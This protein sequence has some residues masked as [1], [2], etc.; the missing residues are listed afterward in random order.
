MK[1]NIYTDQVNLGAAASD[2]LVQQCHQNALLWEELQQGKSSSFVFES[3]K[4]AL[5]R[6]R[7]QS[8]DTDIK[9]LITGSLHLV[10]AV[11]AV[12]EMDKEKDGKLEHLTHRQT[13]QCK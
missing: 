11:L 13:I 12:L 4:E 1:Y 7:L 3:V 6:I 8:K 9:V 10:G 5:N 2:E